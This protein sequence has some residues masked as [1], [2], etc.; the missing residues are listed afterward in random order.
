MINSEFKCSKDDCESTSFDNRYKISLMGTDQ[1]YELEFVVFDHKAEK[2]IGKPIHWLDKKYDR[3]EIPPEV[4]NL[5]GQKFTFIVKISTTKRSISNPN[6]SFEVVYTKSQHGKQL[7]TPSFQR[8]DAQKVP[9][10]KLSIQKKRTPLIPIH[11]K[12]ITNQFHK[13]QGRSKNPNDDNTETDP[14]DIEESR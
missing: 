1:T 6:P 3:F 11:S 10:T 12:R 14:M 4:A 9:T 2:L 7:K 13:F 8:I 5:V